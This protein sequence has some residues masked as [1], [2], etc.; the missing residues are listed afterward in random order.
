[1][2][3]T[4]REQIEAMLTADPQDEFLRY[5]LAMECA[6]AGDDAAAAQQFETLLADRPNYVPAYFQC[7]QVLLRLGR[8]EEAARVL[9]AGI[10]IARQAGDEHAAGELEGL[11]MS[12]A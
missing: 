12:I 11:L 10:P 6:S 8:T 1:M 9:R 2:A 3:Q 7:G 4:R 5:A